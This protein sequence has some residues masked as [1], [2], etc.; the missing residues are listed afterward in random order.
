M[1]ETTLGNPFLA[2]YFTSPE[3]HAR[4]GEIQRM[5]ALLSDPRGASEIE[6]K[7]AIEN[8]AP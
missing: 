3:N 6:I 7:D 1:G 8:D 5:N 4:L 2:M